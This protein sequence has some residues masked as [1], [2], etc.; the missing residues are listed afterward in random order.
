MTEGVELWVPLM[1]QEL[2]GIASNLSGIYETLMEIR[3][4]LQK[5]N[6][7][8]SVKKKAK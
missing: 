4:E 3:A 5:L 7:T 6:E 1:Q 2:K 8:L